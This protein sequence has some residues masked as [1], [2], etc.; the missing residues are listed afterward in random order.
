MKRLIVGFLVVVTLLC[1]C[2]GVSADEATGNRYT[3]DGVTV[4]FDA[5]S[6]FSVEQQEA[7]ANLLVHPEYGTSTAGLMCTLFGH[8]NTSETAITI[9]HKYNV[10]SPRCLQENF[11][12]TSC[13]RC[14]E[15]TVERVSYKYISCCPED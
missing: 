14:G 6:Q 13:S 3:V 8:K 9:T 11:V 1:A 4:V 12:V 5:D 2:V 10:E 7:I 15:S